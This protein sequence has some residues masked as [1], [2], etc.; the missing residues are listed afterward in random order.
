MYEAPFDPAQAGELVDLGNGEVELR[1]ERRLN[2]PL[3]KVWAAISIPERIGA[4]FCE[5][6]FEAAP[7][8]PIDQTFH[9]AGGI[10]G[11]GKVLR[12]EPPRL[13][14]WQWNGGPDE[15][16]SVVTWRLEPDGDDA[17]RIFLTH[18]TPDRAKARDYGHGWHVHLDGL[19]EALNGGRFV[20][21]L[22]ND[23][24]VAAHYNAAFG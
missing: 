12:F 18:R 11:S 7:G 9:H 4:W 8:A 20:F 6:T 10:K 19:V 24:E 1:F 23:A 14:E 2:H 22:P 16:D 13:F 15:A 5:M 21:P 3:D 17:T